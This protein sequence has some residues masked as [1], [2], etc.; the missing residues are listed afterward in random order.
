MLSISISSRYRSNFVQG[1]ILP[2]GLP[3][4]CL[5]VLPTWLALV[6]I[7]GEVAGMHK[8]Q[9]SVQQYSMYAPQSTRPVYFHHIHVYPL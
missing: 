4:V 3:M 6:Y 8:V 1:A 7:S 5:H 2:Y 9:P